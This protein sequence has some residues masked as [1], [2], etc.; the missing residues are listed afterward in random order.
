MFAIIDIETCGG[1]FEFRKGRITEIAIL[2]H[3]GLSVV[4]TYSTLIDPE[5]YITPF[6]T[7][8]TGITNDMVSTAPKFHEVANKII[9]LTENNIF[10]AHSVGFD[11]G[12]IKAEFDSLGYEFKR[13]TLCTVK[14]SRKLLPGKKSYSLGKLCAG[15]GIENKARHRAEGDAVATAEL[16]DILMQA[17]SNHPKYKNKSISQLMQSRPKKVGS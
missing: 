10:V 17:K 4:E 13:D 7:K 12:F 5:C 2:V 16:F 3:D 1:T 11:Y 15:L 8:L 9:A 6:F 14:L